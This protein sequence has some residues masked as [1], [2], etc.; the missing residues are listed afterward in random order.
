MESS[1]VEWRGAGYIIRC[2]T[3][4]RQRVAG[5]RFSRCSFGPA[6]LGDDDLDLM[7]LR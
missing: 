5:R 3:W 1:Q 4:W 6:E 2:G 7:R